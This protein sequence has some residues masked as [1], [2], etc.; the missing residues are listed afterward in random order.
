MYNLRPIIETG[1]KSPFIIA[2]PCS[3]ES[4][5][6]VLATAK[7]IAPMGIAVFRAGVWK[8]R[9]KPGTFEGVGAP[10]LEWLAEVKRTTGMAVTTE[11]ASPVHV[12]QALRGGIDILWLGARTTANPFAV[13]EIAD[14]LRGTDA[15]VMVKNPVSPDIELWTGALERLYNAG[16]TRLAAIHRGFTSYEGGIYRNPPQW[17]LAIELKRRFPALTC[18]CDPSHMAGR[19]E[20]IAELCQRAMDLSYDALMIECHCAPDTALS[21]K[22][23]QLTP[24]ALRQVLSQLVVRNAPLSPEAMAELRAEIDQLDSRLIEILA[25]RM[26]VSRRIGEYKRANSVPILQIRRHDEILSRLASAAELRGMNRNF[27]KIIVEAIH[28]ESIRV[29]MET[30][31]D[32]K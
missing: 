17:A 8:P 28:E 32:K 30:M 2:G 18:V 21:D 29:Q 3:A 4:R 12:E 11:V 5:E 25:Q 16:I 7:A 9:T 27:I 10:A 14:A 24:D 23:Q 20:P 19:R 6:Q 31:H 22:N 26:D 13:Q 1:G 15:R